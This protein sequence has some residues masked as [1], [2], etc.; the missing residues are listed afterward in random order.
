MDKSGT[1]ANSVEQQELFGNSENVEISNKFET[2][3]TESF[4]DVDNADGTEALV[5]DSSEEDTKPLSELQG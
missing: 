2:S 1:S 3:D 5:E 4:Y